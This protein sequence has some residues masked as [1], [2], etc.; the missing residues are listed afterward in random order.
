MRK[1]FGGALALSVL[2]ATVL[3]GAL[4]WNDTQEELGVALVG[5]VDWE[6]NA[7]PTANVLGPNGAEA[8]VSYLTIENTGTALANF[9]IKYG[10][11]T[12][13]IG[14]LVGDQTCNRGNFSGTV[15]G[16]GLDWD[17]PIAPGNLLGSGDSTEGLGQ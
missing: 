5:T 15:R 6:L 10:D 12:V 1:I 16:L 3:G 17:E 13:V 8:V 9:N 7:Y 4:A 2:G 14:N 11:G